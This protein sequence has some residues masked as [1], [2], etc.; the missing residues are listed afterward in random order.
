[1]IADV[2]AALGKAY[3]HG[4]RNADYTFHATRGRTRNGRRTL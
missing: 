2:R 1:M 3:E 4:L